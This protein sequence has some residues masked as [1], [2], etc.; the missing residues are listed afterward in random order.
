MP[1]RT[2]I[3]YYPKLLL[4]VITIITYITTDDWACPRGDGQGEDGIMDTMTGLVSQLGDGLC[5]DTWVPP[6]CKTHLKKADQPP[7]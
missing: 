2:F 7:Q 1:E 5:A 4:S 3:Y 6:A